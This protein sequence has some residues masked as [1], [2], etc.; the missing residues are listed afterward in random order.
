M[1]RDY[2]RHQLLVYL[3]VIAERLCVHIKTYLQHSQ[4]VDSSDLS[5]ISWVC[6]DSSS[7]RLENLEPSYVFL[8]VHT[9][10]VCVHIS[11]HMCGL[12]DSQKY[13][14][15]FQSQYGYLILQFLNLTFTLMYLLHCLC[16]TSGSM[17]LNN[18]L[19]LFSTHARKKEVLCIGQTMNQVGYM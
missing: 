17:K 16:I 13:I 12:L 3:P 2:L 18:C 6:R 4:A 10:L 1:D 7:V 19:Q 9:A 8:S 5:F 11:M 15:S 14:R